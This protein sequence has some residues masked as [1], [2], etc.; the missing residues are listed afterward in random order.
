M[1]KILT[2]LFCLACA[3]C[4]TAAPEYV[5]QE[6]FDAHVRDGIGNT[7]AKLA[8]GEEVTVAYF[9]GSITAQNGWRPKTSKFLGEQYPNA[10]INEIHAAIGGTGSDLGVF[11]VGYDVLRHDPDLVFVE[12]ATNDGGNSPEN[13][14]RQMEGIVRQIWRHDAQ[15]DIVFVYTVTTGSVGDYQN[16]KLARAAG[17]ME[18]LAEFYGIPTINFGKRVAEMVTADKLVMKADEAPEG[19]ILFAKDGVHP[20]DEGHELYLA[21][22]VAAFPAMKALP[23]VNH[24][25]KLEKVFVEDNYENAKMVSIKPEMLEGEWKQLQEGDAMYGFTNRTGEMWLTATPGSKLTFKFRGTQVKFYDILAPNAG[26]VWVTVDGKKSEKPSARYDS[27]CS[28]SRLATLW[29]FSDANSD[30]N[31]VHTVTVE[32]DANQP[33]RTVVKEYKEGDPKYD[34]TNWW[35]G[36][37]MILGDVVE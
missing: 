33:D 25:G 13:I 6:S 27:Y 16:G 3:T 11:R 19:K 18:M 24:A 36:K 26:Q 23:A 28:W 29:A 34:G 30:P 35:V 14:W 22:I 20:L 10:K 17:A 15:T 31:E 9:G 12:F 7:I 2:F 8:A 37:I 1:K 5:Q 21:D 32:L 4:L